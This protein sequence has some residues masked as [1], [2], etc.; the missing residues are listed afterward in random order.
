MVKQNLKSLLEVV[1]RY[2]NLVKRQMYLKD[3]GED[4][5]KINELNGKILQLRVYFLK[6]ITNIDALVKQEEKLLEKAS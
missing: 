2:D 1:A 4:S 5:D 3:K 6:L